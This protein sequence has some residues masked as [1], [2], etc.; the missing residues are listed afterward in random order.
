MRAAEQ[1]DAALI[2]QQLARRGMTVIGGRGIALVQRGEAGDRADEQRAGGRATDGPHLDRAL[3]RRDELE[4]DRGRMMLGGRDAHAPRAERFDAMLAGIDGHRHAGG[5]RLAV[6]LDDRVRRQ[7]A[8]RDR[9]RRDAIDERVL[10]LARELL[11]L[12]LIRGARFALDGLEHAQRV[13]EPAGRRPAQREVELGAERRCEPQA[14]LEQRARVARLAG[15]DQLATAREQR[16]RLRRLV[17][18]VA[19]GGRDAARQHDRDERAD[20]N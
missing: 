5:D 15:F 8:E 14:V 16:R 11:A 6:E 1:V 2:A 7:P 17:V 3:V 9:Q 4:R 12:R 19:I 18:V 20:Q 13:D 10:A